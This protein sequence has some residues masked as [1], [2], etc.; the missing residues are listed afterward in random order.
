MRPEA[1]PVAPA[2]LSGLTELLGSAC[3]ESLVARKAGSARAEDLARHVGSFAELPGAVL[4]MVDGEHQP[5]GLLV[6]R[7]VPAGAFTETG[8]LFI[9]AIC[10]AVG[11]RRQGIGHA[12]ISEATAIADEAGV[13]HIYVAPQP[14][15]RGVQRFFVRLGLAPVA[16]YRYAKTAVLRRRLSA[17]APRS[18]RWNAEIR[19]RRVRGENRSLAALQDDVPSSK[20]VR[21]AVQMRLDSEST[22]MIS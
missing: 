9:E 15:Q 19:R 4:L 3:D 5:V 7:L 17:D 10:V 6:G 12:L 1:R 18:A 21:R 13:E 2:D 16:G 22:T 11:H 8:S 20:Q 14:G